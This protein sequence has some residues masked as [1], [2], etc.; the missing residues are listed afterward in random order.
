MPPDS[1]PPDTDRPPLLGT[2]RRM[3]LLVL[4]SLLLTV[5]IF[6]LLTGVYG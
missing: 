6:A 1:V 2:W 5:L 3:Y 4:I